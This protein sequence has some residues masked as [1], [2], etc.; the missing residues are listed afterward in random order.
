MLKNIERNV[1]RWTF[2]MLFSGN[3]KGFISVIPVDKQIKLI[4]H[5]ILI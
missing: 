3:S 2:L 5:E 4:V 1:N